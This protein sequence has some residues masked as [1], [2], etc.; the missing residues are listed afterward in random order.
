MVFAHDSFF[1]FINL[2]KI[3]NLQKAYYPGDRPPYPVIKDS[4]SFRD[5]VCNFN[6]SDLGMFAFWGLMGRLG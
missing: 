6:R 3:G 2:F 1:G 5:V 4:P